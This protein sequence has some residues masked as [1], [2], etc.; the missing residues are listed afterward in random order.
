MSVE[1]QDGYKAEVSSG[2]WNQHGFHQG[3]FMWRKGGVSYMGT[4]QPEFLTLAI[5]T[6]IHATFYVQP[7]LLP[8]EARK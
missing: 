7:V 3:S 6:N 2:S 5:V 1:D 4:I 8:N